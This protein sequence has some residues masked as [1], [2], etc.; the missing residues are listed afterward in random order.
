[1]K[2]CVLG[3]GSGGNSTFVEQNGTRL[4]V[5]AGLHAKEIVQRLAQINV[6]AGSLDGIL[7]SHEH[8]DHIQGA[9]AIARKFKVPVYISPRAREHAPFS[10]QLVRYYPVS[11]GIPIQ[12][13]A[14][15]VTPFSTPHDS[16]DPL[17][18]ALRTQDC[19]ACVITDIG[20]VSETIRERLR[21][22]D[23][24][25]IESNHDLEML[26]TGPYPWTLK[27][28]VMSNYGHLSNEALAYFFA[29][30]FDG[31]Q[32]KVMLTHLS[33]QNNHP[34]LAYVSALRALERKSRDTDLQI[35]MQDEISE[36]LEI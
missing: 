36:I 29:E 34:Q 35:S 31:T 11:A 6:D 28:R 27:Q 22:T 30:Y 12:I 8:H 26:R 9:A 5:D 7:I 10:F 19:R 3:S 20:Y 13:G 32:R 14:I 25:V 15:T 4:L 16:I 33:K 1:M 17:G 2:I 24:V 23:I 18:F 21:N